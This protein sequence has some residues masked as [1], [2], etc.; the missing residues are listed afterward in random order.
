MLIRS[1]FALLGGVLTY[2]STDSLIL[3]VIA[4]VVSFVLVD[5]IDFD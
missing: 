4:A 2:F 1:V 3:T 5:V